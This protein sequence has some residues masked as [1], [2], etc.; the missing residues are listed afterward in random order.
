M[1]WIS[2]QEC[3]CDLQVKSFYVGEDHVGDPPLLKKIAAA[4]TTG[5]TLTG[6]IFMKR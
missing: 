4:L 5:T 6:A 2:N 3:C 1:S